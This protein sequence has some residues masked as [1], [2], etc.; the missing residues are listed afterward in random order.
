MGRL[1]EWLMWLILAVCASSV[2]G[3]LAPAIPYLGPVGLSQVASYTAWFVLI[4]SIVAVA[5]F[6]IWV[7]RRRARH[8]ILAVIALFAALGA[9]T[10][11]TRMWRMAEASGVRIDIAQTLGVLSVTQSGAPDESAVYGTYLGTP[12]GAAIYRPRNLRAHS[13]PILLYVHGGGWIGGTRFDRSADMRWYADRG[14]L[15][16]SVDYALSSNERH[17]WNEAEEQ[18]GCALVW[19][20]ANAERYDGDIRR[21]SMLGDSAGGNLVINAAYQASRNELTSSCG[22]AILPVAAVATIYPAVDPAAVYDNDNALA[23]R[24]GRDMAMKYLGGS[25]QQFPDRYARTTSRSYIHASAPPTLII[26]GEVD[27]LVPSGATLT[28]ADAAR[29]AGIDIRLLQVPYGQ[30]A[31]DRVIGNI[32]DQIDRQAVLQ[33]LLRHGQGPDGGEV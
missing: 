6:S 24:Y 1:F 2:A 18:I 13:S 29:S 23:G 15:V 19:V 28:F 5:S 21:L 7:R 14:W 17:L 11:Y 27:Q 26:V 31:F 8:L 16:I 32:G 12:L 9:A 25:P 20:G 3:A 30:H 10:V 33:F 22:G 4:P